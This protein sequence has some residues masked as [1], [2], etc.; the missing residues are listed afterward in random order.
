MAITNAMIIENYKASAGISGPLHTYAKWKQLGYQVKRGEKSHHLL[1]I[2]KQ[3]SKT[4]KNKET[5][6]ETMSNR[7]IMKTAYFFT[8]EQVE[9]IQK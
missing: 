3:T 1:T 4:V 7:M 9:A 2:W 6:E 5:G 8:I